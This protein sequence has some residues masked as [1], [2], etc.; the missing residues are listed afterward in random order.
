MNL[1]QDLADTLTA[2]LPT[3]KVYGYPAVIDAITRPTVCLWTTGV[4][5]LPEAPHSYLATYTLQVF[6]GH[7]DP[8]R[9]D[10][11]LD[12]SLTD[13][14]AVLWDQ[15]SYLLD[16]AERTISEDGKIHSWTLTINRVLQITPEEA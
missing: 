6:T 15:P 5:H 16:R 14:L 9:A 2:A 4:Q 11:A 10:A 12:D 8:E 1:R 3:Y 13:L 7:Q